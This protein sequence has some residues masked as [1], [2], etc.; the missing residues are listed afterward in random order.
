MKTFLKS[1]GQGHLRKRK[2]VTSSKMR[3]LLEGDLQINPNATPIVHAPRKV[4]ITIKK[5]LENELEILVKL[6][7]L[8]RVSE[9]TPWVS[10]LVVARKSSG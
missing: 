4:P 5:D 8:V 10:S 3:F 9:P 1:A 2:Y 6:V 7:I